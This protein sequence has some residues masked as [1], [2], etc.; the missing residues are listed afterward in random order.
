MEIYI[1]RKTIKLKKRYLL[2]TSDNLGPSLS[3]LFEKGKMALWNVRRSVEISKSFVPG[4]V[5]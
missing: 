4:I 1:K 3:V 2:I 5:P